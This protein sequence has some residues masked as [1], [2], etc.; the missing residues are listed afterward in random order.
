MERGNGTGKHRHTERPA[1]NAASRQKGIAP[2]SQRGERENKHSSR[3]GDQTG[4]WTGPRTRGL[5]C[6]AGVF[7][8]DYV[9]ITL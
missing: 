4:G 5:T 1:A 3:R 7:C 9:R 6:P 2:G 8:D